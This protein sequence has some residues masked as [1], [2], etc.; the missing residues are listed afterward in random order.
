MNKMQ[1]FQ[2]L[3][4]RKAYLD[5][6]AILCG[7]PVLESELSSVEA[8]AEMRESSKRLATEPKVDWSLSFDQ[9]RVLMNS[10]IAPKLRTLN[11]GPVSIWTEDTIICGYVTLRSILDINFQFGEDFAGEAVLVVAAIDLKD[12]LLLDFHRGEA[13][14]N[15]EIS[16]QGNNWSKIQID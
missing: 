2:Y 1:R 6:L 10:D 4:A 8:A 16:F 11:P 12:R 13:G 5:H 3:K 14:T 7:R 15:V 9:Y